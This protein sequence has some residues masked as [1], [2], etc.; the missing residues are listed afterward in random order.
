MNR[1]EYVTYDAVELAGLIRAKEVT[2][3][4]LI[5]VS[6][7]Q[8]EAV[9][10]KVNAVVHDRYERAYEV[11]DDYEKQL[12]FSGVPFLLKD[13]GQS[14]KGERMTSGAR[15]LQE[16]RASQTSHYASALKSA[17]FIFTGFTNTPE[18]ALKNITEPALHGPTKNPWNT[19]YSAGGSSGGAAAAVA[20]G[21]VP[22]AGASDGGGSIRIPASFTGLIGLKPTRGRTP[23]G[24][25][26]GRNW[27]GAATDFVLSRTAR[28]TAAALD[29]LS[30]YQRFAAFHS[31]LYKDGY[32]QTLKRR[33][34]NQRT[35]GFTLESPTGEPVSEEAKRAVEK[36]IRYVEKE[37]H[38]AEE[39][40]W[41][42]DAQA[43]MHDY[44]VMNSGEMHGVM[45]QLERRFGAHVWD[46][47]EFET[48]M[49]AKAGES[50]LGSDYAASIHAWDV[51]SIHMHDFHETYDFF[52]T[53]T[54]AKCAPKVGELTKSIEEQNMWKEQLQRDPGRAPL[55]IYD[56]FA[57]SFSYT[58]FTQLANMTGQPAISLP[59]HVGE[60]GLPI[61]VQVMAPKGKDHR[62][63]RLAAHL[64]Q[65]DVWE[66]LRQSPLLKDRTFTR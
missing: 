46:E 24:P 28:D 10:G 59:L 29:A 40:K 2:A 42:V 8:Q 30:V 56:M 57:D 52:V 7:E 58:P 14:L 4:E 61:G 35:F 41:P 22:V 20:S 39:V 5:R 23:V 18:F 48:W 26:V 25:G 3:E 16:E 63:L 31:P 65:S 36:L 12:P 9:N 47:V 50:V 43:L 13:I 51:A 64:E 1:E 19:V 54:T 32:L 55:T 33:P 53:P 21:I 60:N 44:Y 38:Y 11:A 15:L 17:G 49:L 37:G 6:A 27:Q 66:G 62:L 34:Q 45:R